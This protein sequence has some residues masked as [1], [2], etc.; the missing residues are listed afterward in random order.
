MSTGYHTTAIVATVST[1]YQ[2]ICTVV[3]KNTGKKESEL[4]FLSEHKHAH[5]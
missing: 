3:L 2:C 5:R 4:D 1:G